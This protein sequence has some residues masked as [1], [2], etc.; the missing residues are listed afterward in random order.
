[1]PPTLTI[2]AEDY[3]TIPEIA[4][5]RAHDGTILIKL[6]WVSSTGEEDIRVLSTTR[7][8]NGRWV[9]QECIDGELAVVAR[10]GA[11]PMQM[12]TDVDVIER[13]LRPWDARRHA[14]MRDVARTPVV[15]D[16]I[17]GPSETW[18]RW[19]SRD[20]VAHTAKVDAPVIV[21]SAPRPPPTNAASV[22]VLN[23]F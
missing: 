11:R 9:A 14:L 10:A 5:A 8:T 19:R 21:S 16:I 18:R 6:G 12:V 22:V 13:A 1:M 3:V 2:D 7:D 15:T 20:P 23:L 17:M 4:A